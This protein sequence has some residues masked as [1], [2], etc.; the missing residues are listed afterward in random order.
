MISIENTLRIGEYDRE[1]RQAILVMRDQ[2]SRLSMDALSGGKE[3]RQRIMV[4][5]VITSMRLAKANSISKV[6]S[7][8]CKTK[9][10]RAPPILL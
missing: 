5:Q 6:I 2:L 7:V 1:R 9:S 3:N 10:P 8:T 4:R